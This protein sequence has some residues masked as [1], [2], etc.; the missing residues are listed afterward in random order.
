MKDEPLVIDVYKASKEIVA[1]IHK[2]T[3]YGHLFI[4]RCNMN[5]C[6]VRLTIVTFWILLYVNLV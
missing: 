4:N 3:K 6:N 2:K 5:I 1:L